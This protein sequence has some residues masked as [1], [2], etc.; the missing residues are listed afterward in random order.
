MVG[1]M[2]ESLMALY[3]KIDCSFPDDPK[4]VEAGDLAELAYVRCVLRARE[5]LTDGVIDRR[6]VSRWLAGVRGKPATHL[7]RL[8]S[9]GLLVEHPEGW[10]IPLSAWRR[11][12]PLRAEVDEK[13]EAEAERKRVAREKKSAERPPGHDEDDERNPFLS[14]DRPGQ[15][16]PEPEPE[17]TSPPSPS[18]TSADAPSSD[19]GDVDRILLK[20]AQREA[21]RFGDIVN[22][23]AWIRKR[24][25]TLVEQVWREDPTRKNA[26]AIARKMAGVP[27]QLVTEPCSNPECV[28]G[29]VYVTE[30]GAEVLAHCPNHPSNVR[31]SA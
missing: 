11:W 17:P 24:Y 30:N 21:A 19:D 1:R 23:T 3:A 31:E 6:V 16:E 25:E 7:E 5:N 4:T 12:N 22:P 13:R 9:V 18:G 29:W 10:R 26:L 27:V 2:V 15:P 8:V 28:N 20:L 14:E